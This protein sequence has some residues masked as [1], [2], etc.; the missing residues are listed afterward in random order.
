VG[1]YGLLAAELMALG[2]PTVAYLRPDLLRHYPCE[3]PLI[4]ANPSNLEETLLWWY[5]HRDECERIREAGWHYARAVHHPAIL[6]RRCLEC[7][8]S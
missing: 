4:N 6:A 7:Y 8:N 1:S 5:E 2:V 3:P